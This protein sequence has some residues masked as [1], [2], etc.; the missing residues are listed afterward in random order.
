MSQLQNS[1]L[2]FSH[3]IKAKEWNEST[4]LTVNGIN[5]AEIQLHRNRNCIKF[6]WF[7]EKLIHFY[8]THFSIVNVPL[9]QESNALAE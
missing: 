9:E 7:F 3:V 2:Q 6:R 4:T 5:I 8:A 1:T